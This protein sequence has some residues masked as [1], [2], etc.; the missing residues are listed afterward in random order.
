MTD[1]QFAELIKA[2]PAIITSL[3]TLFIGIVVALSR[4]RDEKADLK[5]EKLVETTAQ[6]HTLADGNLSKIT[7]E[8]KLVNARY[9]ELQKVVVEL[10]KDKASATE[11]ARKLAEKVSHPEVKA[12]SG[13]SEVV[14]VNKPDEPVPVKP[15]PDQKTKSK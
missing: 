9:E 11:V 10:N 7:T 5:V 15:L 4:K 13:P 8:L 14:V 6:I 3:G 2:L 1:T 12:D